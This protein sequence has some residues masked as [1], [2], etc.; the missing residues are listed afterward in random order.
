MR[1]N[2]QL[3]VKFAQVRPLTVEFHPSLSSTTQKRFVYLVLGLCEELHG[4]E[5]HNHGVT[6]WKSSI[7]AELYTTIFLQSFER[8]IE[9]G[10]TERVFSLRR[11]R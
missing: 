4:R 8:L 6:V 7:P 10:H 3:A 9:Q 5:C 1:A 2:R 11:K